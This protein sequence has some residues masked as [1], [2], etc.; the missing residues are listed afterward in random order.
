MNMWGRRTVG[1]NRVEGELRCAAPKKEVKYYKLFVE[2]LTGNRQRVSGFVA[3]LAH[4][5]QRYLTAFVS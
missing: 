4:G 5:E 1:S 3:I 2:M